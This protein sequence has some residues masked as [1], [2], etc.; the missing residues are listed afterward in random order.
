MKVIVF[1]AAGA[2]LWFRFVTKTVL[3]T[4]G[5][6]SSCWA[7]LAQCKGLGR[8]SLCPTWTHWGEP[9]R[10]GEDTT[11]HITCTNQRVIPCHRTSWSAIERKRRG[12]R[13][14]L[15]ILNSWTVW[16]LIYPW[17]W[18]VAAL[19]PP[20]FC[21]LSQLGA[22]EM[23][24]CIPVVLSCL[25]GLTCTGTIPVTPLLQRNLQTSCFESR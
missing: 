5:C 11:K 9:E 4:R 18:G 7:E 22:E 24:E 17:G 21:F 16:A 20:L 2:V 19:A 8:F 10:L 13:G 6:F 3:V 12:P 25:L 15:A 1:T 23:W 14:N